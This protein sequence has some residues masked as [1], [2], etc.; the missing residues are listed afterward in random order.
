MQNYVWFLNN[1]SYYFIS[2]EKQLEYE[3]PDELRQ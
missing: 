2:S 3:I 1:S